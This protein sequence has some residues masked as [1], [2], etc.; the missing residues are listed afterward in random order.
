MGK[1][2]AKAQSLPKVITSML[3]FMA[4]DHRIYIKVSNDKVLGFVR[5]GE[6]NLFYRDFV[7]C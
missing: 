2:S 3:K 4:D 7:L 5:T 6:K 1:L